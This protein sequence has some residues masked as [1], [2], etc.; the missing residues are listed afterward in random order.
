M[1][2]SKKI[3]LVNM[4]KDRRVRDWGTPEYFKIVTGTNPIPFWL[5]EIPYP[6]E[7]LKELGEYINILEKEYITT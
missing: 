5:F 6:N 3:L 4:P 2:K 1:S 7:K